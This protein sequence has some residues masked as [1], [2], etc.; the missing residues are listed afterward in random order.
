MSSGLGLAS[1]PVAYCDSLEAL[2]AAWA[3]GFSRSARV[4]TASPAVYA[5]GIEGVE[6]LEDSPRKVDHAA[7][8]M[9]GSTLT[10]STYAALD[11]Q[12]NTAR[13]ALLAS[14]CLLMLHRRLQKATY[15]G[16]MDFSEPRAAFMVSTGSVAHDEVLNAPWSAFFTEHDQYTE[17]LYPVRTDVFS[18][19]EPRRWQKFHR[20]HISRLCYAAAVRLT[21]PFGALSRRRVLVFRENELVEDVV[22]GLVL[23]GYAA[24]RLK[25]VSVS[26]EGAYSELESLVEGVQ[27]VLQGFLDQWFTPEVH[28]AAQRMFRNDLAGD[29]KTYWAGRGGW[30]EALQPYERDKTVLLTNFPG[31]AEAIA[32]ADSCHELHIPVVAAQHGITREISAVHSPIEV[33]F[34]NGVADLFLVFNEAAQRI[35]DASPF[36]LGHSQT[37][38][39]SSAYGRMAGRRRRNANFPIL[40]IS[41]ALMKG[42][43]NL[44]TGGASDFL[45]S[46]RERAILEQVLSRLPH[47]VL[48]KSYP[49]RDRYVDPDPLFAEIDRY[50]NV[51]RFNDR[52]DLRYFAHEHELLIASRATSTIGWCLMADRPLVFIDSPDD[53]PLSKRAR[54]L[55]DAGLF[56]FD[57]RDPDMLSALRMFLSQPLAEIK[58]QWKERAQDRALLIR[59]LVSA[60]STGAGRRG[61]HAI[62]DL[63]SGDLHKGVATFKEALAADDEA[64]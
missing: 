8:W 15:L 64:G 63:Q 45:R 33:F 46:E 3:D 52:V 32:L 48:Y 19:N 49:S 1:V 26:R 22:R 42:N 38:G 53:S 14:R 39:L 54:Q 62:K 12:A 51:A 41:T 16:P 27:P 35:T 36:R 34:E 17:R 24:R 61:A 28:A 47:N 21:W 40:Y 50:S 31:S 57:W 9:A 25:P 23:H 30:L 59:Q 13:M 6:R 7:Y 37:V 20:F 18:A 43:V 58:S 2:E 44:A 11:R 10:R 55:F 4:R 5:A 29:L 56:V 60:T